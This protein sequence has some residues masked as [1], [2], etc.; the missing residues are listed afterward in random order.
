MYNQHR[1]FHFVIPSVMAFA[2]SGV[3]TIV[4]GFFVGNSLGDI[5]LASINVGF[6]ISAFIQA[7]GTGV[8]LSGAIRF[9]ILR[10]QKK[11]D[12]SVECFSSTI[13]LL[14]LISTF[15]TGFIL[16]LLSPLL[17]LLGA[18]GDLYQQTAEYVQVIALGT[19]F[20]IFATGLVPFIRN[21]GGA[22]FAMVSMIAGFLTNIG[23]D[24]LFVW[25]YGQG[26]AGAAWATIIGQAVTMLA[27]VFYLVKKKIGFSINK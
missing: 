27:T 26:M 14:F 15:L 24:Y 25:I 13:L 20:Q 11:H 23:L 7:V 3:Y 9:T 21:L 18:Q 16:V 2:L 5:G 19:V 17:H 8:G 10:G 1:F 4:D 22:T 12:E 6:P